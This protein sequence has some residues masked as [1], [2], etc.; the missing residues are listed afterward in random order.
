LTT[1]FDDDVK[2]V[3]STPGA[4]DVKIS[5]M[6]EAPASLVVIGDRPQFDSRVF[7]HE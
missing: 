7:S 4:G 6:A 5:V 3:V 2:D 1:G